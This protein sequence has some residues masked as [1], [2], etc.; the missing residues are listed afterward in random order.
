[1]TG[2][3]E[4]IE[5]PTRIAELED[6]LAKQKR[7]EKRN[8]RHA[9]AHGFL[10]GILAL[11]RPGDIVIDCGANLGEVAAPL[12]ATGAEVHAFEPDPYA[13]AKLSERLGGADNVTL[14]QQAVSTEAGTLRLMRAANF[15]DNPKGGSVKSTLLSGGRGISD[16]DGIDV[17]VIDFVAFLKDI[18]AK[19]GPVTFLKMDIEGAELDLL[20]AMDAAGL[21]DHIRCTVAETRENKFKDLRPRYRE[22]RAAFG[23][24][25]AP[26]HV[27]LD[28]I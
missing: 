20:A 22:L 7:R 5:D 18:I 9:R 24:K 11:L 6:Q 1:M 10:D 19:K 27:N 17:E 21:F 26:N 8:L 13:F 3:T 2:E 16:E 28:W 15:D 14:H 25:Y 12:A 23:E 4:Q